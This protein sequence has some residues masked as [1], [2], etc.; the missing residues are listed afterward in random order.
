MEYI[1]GIEYSDRFISDEIRRH[2]GLK[3]EDIFKI[4]IIKFLE[5]RYD[6]CMKEV[7]GIESGYN[8]VWVME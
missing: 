2:R 4:A 7:N 3:L 6:I 5:K 1:D 8:K